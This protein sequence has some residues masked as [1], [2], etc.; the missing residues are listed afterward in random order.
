MNFHDEEENCKIKLIFYVYTS[1]K[2]S[3]FSVAEFDSSQF[4]ATQ[5]IHESTKRGN[6]QVIVVDAKS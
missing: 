2:E 5:S 4:V 1:R 3:L 6:W